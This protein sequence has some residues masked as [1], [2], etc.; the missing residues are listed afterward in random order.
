MEAAFSTPT[1]SP[2]RENM[3]PPTYDNAVL[4]Q[5]GQADPATLLPP[6]LSQ[7]QHSQG[8][9]CQRSVGHRMGDLRYNKC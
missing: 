8:M 9:R 3:P 4:T 1:T 2:S 7:A 6:P 5:T